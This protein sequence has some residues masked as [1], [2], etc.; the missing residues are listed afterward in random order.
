MKPFSYYKLF[1]DSLEK[2]LERYFDLFP[3]GLTPTQLDLIFYQKPLYTFFRGVDD[4]K[5]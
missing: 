4:I 1:I 2:H 5:F 3:V